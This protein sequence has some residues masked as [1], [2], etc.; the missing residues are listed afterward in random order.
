MNRCVCCGDIIPEGRQ[1][2]PACEKGERRTRFTPVESIPEQAPKGF[3]KNNGEHL[4]EFM[5]MN[6]KKAKMDIAGMDYAHAY[7]AYAATRTSANYY[8]L[9]INVRFINGEIYL[10]RTDMEE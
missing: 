3:R 7:S 10:V 9:P 1:V 4:Y 5:S 8:G 6:V 2:C